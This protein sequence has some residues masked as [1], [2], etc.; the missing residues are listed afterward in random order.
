MRQVCRLQEWQV[1]HCRWKDEVW[2]WQGGAPR[3]AAFGPGPREARGQADLTTQGYDC[4]TA[5]VAPQEHAGGSRGT[6]S[7]DRGTPPCPWP[8]PASAWPASEWPAD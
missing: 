5:H 8:Q 2:G 7:E 3:P 1:G 6:G 4:P